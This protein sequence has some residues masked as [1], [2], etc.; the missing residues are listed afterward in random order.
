MDVGGLTSENQTGFRSYMQSEF[1]F[2][3]FHVLIAVILCQYEDP[4]A[5]TKK[6]RRALYYPR[7]LFA[8]IVEFC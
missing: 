3:D 5:G 4:G 1:H 6:N 2:L 7:V 8:L